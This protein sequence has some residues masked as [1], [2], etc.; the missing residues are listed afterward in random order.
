MNA[1]TVDKDHP[2][3]LMLQ[4]LIEQHGLRAMLLGIL[5]AALRMR[6]D[7]VRLRH[8]DLPDH[9]RRDVGLPPVATHRGQRYPL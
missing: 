9:L 3:D 5:T 8:H 1:F 2:P 4:R 7:R 6:R